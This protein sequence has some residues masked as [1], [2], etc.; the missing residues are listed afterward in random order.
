M[1]VNVPKLT[2]FLYAIEN[3]DLKTI[4]KDVINEFI[5][6]VLPELEHLPSGTLADFFLF[7][8]VLMAYYKKKK[9]KQKEK[10]LYNNMLSTL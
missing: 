6:K 8:Y 1:L 5:S 10:R 7:C 9:K 2:D 3:E 4:S